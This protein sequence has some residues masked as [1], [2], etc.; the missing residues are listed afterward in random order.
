MKN[1]NCGL[2]E[3]P[4]RLDRF[5][6]QIYADFYCGIYGV[7]GRALSQDLIKACFQTPL[8]AGAIT[9]PGIH[10]STEPNYNLL[11]VLDKQ[12]L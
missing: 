5:K 8:P 6:C 10:Q 12:L 1:K 4:Q 11:N 2:I 3:K 7:Y 9:L